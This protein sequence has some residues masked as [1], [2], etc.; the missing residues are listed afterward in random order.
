MTE[1]NLGRCQV[2]NFNRIESLTELEK[3]ELSRVEI[4]DQEIRHLTSLTKI[5]HSNLYRNI[6][7]YRF[8]IISKFI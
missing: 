4:T 1:L 7:N 2:K 5:T 6:S 8:E 3:S